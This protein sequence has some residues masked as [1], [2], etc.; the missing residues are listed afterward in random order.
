MT[1][2]KHMSMWNNHLDA[3]DDNSVKDIQLESFEGSRGFPEQTLDV[4]KHP[5]VLPSMNLLSSLNL[6]K[7]VLQT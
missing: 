7:A 5:I 2:F 3:S 4:N 6:I 1:Y